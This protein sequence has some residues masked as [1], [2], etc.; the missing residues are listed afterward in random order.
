MY[1]LEPVWFVVIATS[2][3][4]WLTSCNQPGKRLGCG[5]WASGPVGLASH[6]MRI[7]QKE[8]ENSEDILTF[9]ASRECEKQQ[10]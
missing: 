6:K 7:K 9:L 8:R 2:R 1:E 3:Q 10:R 4:G 5:R